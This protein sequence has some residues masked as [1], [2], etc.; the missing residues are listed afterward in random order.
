MAVRRKTK[1]EATKARQPAITAA[2][3]SGAWRHARRPLLQVAGLA[4]FLA[5]SAAILRLLDARVNAQLVERTRPRL[6][7][8]AVP[9]PIQDLVTEDLSRRLLPLLP[10]EWTGDGLCAALGEEARRCGWVSELHAVRR[11][12]DGVFV[13]AARYHEP[14]AMVDMHDGYAL[15]DRAGVR[16]PGTYTFHRT[17][18]LIQGV[19]ETAPL[20][21]ARWGGADMAAG[22]AVLDRILREPY[23]DQITGVMVENFGGRV[24]PNASHI[25][26]ATDRAGGRIHWGSAP[27][28]ELVENTV[29]QKLA[30]LRANFRGTGRADAD[31]AGIDISTFADRFVVL[32]P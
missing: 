28:T 31:H 30:I 24:D 19:R 6:E 14:F 11:R 15:V 21:G 5:M 10:R 20:P 7:F 17:W 16:L 22:I 23:G 29:E 26:L 3:L 27:G 12:S 4:L 13:I 9:P 32:A 18:K 8:P 25:V 1:R 2:W